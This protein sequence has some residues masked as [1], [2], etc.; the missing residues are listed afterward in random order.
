MS[1][2]PTTVSQLVYKT[3]QQFVADMTTAYGS[4][5]GILPNLQPGDPELA[6]F[7]AAGT[8][9]VFI[10][11]LLQ[12]I[13][14]AARASTATGSD[15]DS[16]CADFNFY[17]LPATYAQGAV[18]LAALSA[19]VVQVPIPT[20]VLVQT[21]GG[22]IQYQLIADTTQSSWS[23]TLNAYVLP[24]GQTSINATAQATVAGSAN[25]V[26]PGQLTQFATGVAGIA[27]VTNG[28]A[29][30]NGLD[31]ELDPAFR[32]RFVQYLA[33]LSKA[34]LGAY[35]SAANSVQQGLDLL[36]LENTNVSLQTQAGI[37]T[38]I[39]DDGTGSPPATLLN[40]VLTALNGVRAFGIQAAV[41]APTVVNVTVVTGIVI[42]PDPTETNS[43]IQSNVQAAIVN[44]I[45]TVVQLSDDSQYLYLNNIVE[46]AKDADPNVRAV[47]VGSTTLNGVAADLQIGI[48]G[49]PRTTTSNVTVNI[50]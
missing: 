12:I 8:Q 38:M 1:A 40:N 3:L 6:V 44:Y 34:T 49:L 33:S 24:A 2:S 4:S 22:A 48:G 47:V 26:Q 14:T 17:R 11:S 23:T 20:G 30:T 42:V 36:A 13:W 5:L 15:L 45:N 39:V 16:F 37:N 10:E 27:T 7:E 25:N 28:A 31:Q 19:P 50:G 46:V 35:L 41:K 32:A 21:P 43:V 29:I 9:D 18:T